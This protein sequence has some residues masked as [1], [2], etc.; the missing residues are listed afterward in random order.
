VV[1][2]GVPAASVWWKYIT[3]VGL[4]AT[5]DSY[6]GVL[7]HKCHRKTGF[8]LHSLTRKSLPSVRFPKNSTFL[9][10]YLHKVRFGTTDLFFSCS[11][12]SVSAHLRTEKQH[13]QKISVLVLDY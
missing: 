1:F 6:R 3:A 12:V 7:R 10:A 4:F 9:L 13:S 11:V 2:F 8:P 5:P